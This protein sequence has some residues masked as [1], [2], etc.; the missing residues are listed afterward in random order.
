MF[1]SRLPRA[2]GSELKALQNMTGILQCFQCK[3]RP[4][5]AVKIRE[6]RHHG[7]GKVLFTVNICND[8][9]KSIDW[10]MVSLTENDALASSRP[11]KVLP[12]KMYKYLMEQKKKAELEKQKLESDNYLKKE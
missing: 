5:R 8:C 7:K 2:S 9:F 3:K 6:E 12:E 11:I 4:D 10:R 1:T